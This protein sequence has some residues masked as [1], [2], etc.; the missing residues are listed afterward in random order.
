[1]RFGWRT[2]IGLALLAGAALL[3]AG[4]AALHAG[5][6]AKAHALIVAGESGEAPFTTL[7][8]EWAQR[9][10]TLLTAKAGIA[11][12]RVAVLVEQPDALKSVARGP[13]TLA[14]VKKVLAGWT[15]EV[16][17]GDAVVV[18]LLGHGTGDA[19]GSK[20]CLAGPD[21]TAA[22]LAEALKL[23]PT[24]DVCVVHAGSASHGFV[25]ALSHPDRIVIASTNNPGQGNATYFAEFFLRAWEQPGADANGNGK[26]E[27]LEL[28]N[29]SAQECAKWYL[30]QY[31]D[32]KEWRTEGKQSRALWQKFYGSNSEKKMGAPMD[33]EAED[34]EPQLGEWGE[35]WMG[36]RMCTEFAQLDDNGDRVGS[37]VF[38]NTALT[39][40]KGS[41]PGEDGKQAAAAVPGQPRG[42]AGLPEF[43]D[44]EQKSP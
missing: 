25:A 31:Y 23:V 15:P 18:V 26:L 40:L 6:A 4:A 36:R 27:W 16:K 7:F 33:P 5:E 39:P 9:F 21:L 32:G 34:A 44:P 14:E 38:N 11:P 12:E 3:D 42:L 1:M 10:H 37:A 17:P 43:K 28:F 22:D 30:R 8:P 29:R 13:S 41:E 20:L 19:A 2:T 24:R 35:Q